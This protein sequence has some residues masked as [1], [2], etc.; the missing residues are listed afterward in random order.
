MSLK[1]RFGSLSK[2]EV[3]T[4]NVNVSTFALLELFKKATQATQEFEF[5]IFVDQPKAGTRVPY[6][7]GDVGHTFVQL[8]GGDHFIILGFYPKKGYSRL[9]FISRGFMSDRDGMLVNDG[10]TGSMG[11]PHEWDVKKLYRVNRQ[12]ANEIMNLIENW[13]TGRKYNLVTCNCTNFAIDCGRSCGLQIP[14]GNESSWPHPFNEIR[15]ANP[16]DLGE[17]IVLEGGTRR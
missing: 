2:G 14:S 5:T 4:A 8:S 16:G 7:N 15:S 9:D 3:R 13:H 17:D 1:V 11:L 10:K 6:F 12:Q